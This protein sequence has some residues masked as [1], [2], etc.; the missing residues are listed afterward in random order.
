MLD[1]TEENNRDLYYDVDKCITYCRQIPDTPPS[2]NVDYHMFWRVGKPFGRKQTLPIKSYL[3]TQNRELTRLHVWSNV[4]LTTNEYL[5][6]FLP[7][8]DFHIWDP[9]KEAKGTPI[10]GR[11]EIINA[12]DSLN[13]AG[14]DLFRILCLHKHGG[15]Y[16]DF[17]IVYLRNLGPVLGQEFMYKWSFQEH[18]INGAVMRLWKDSRLG[19]SLLTEIATVPRGGGTAWSTELYQRVRQYNKDWTVFP[20][21]FFNTEWQM[22]SQYRRNHPEFSDYDNDQLTIHIRNPM[23]TSS[24]CNEL[25]DGVFTWHWHNLWDEPICDG[26]KWAVLE[27]KFNAKV[28][29]LYGI[30]CML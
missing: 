22:D 14:G 23:K 16:A 8:I 15:F 21:A 5:R 24:F 27:N 20:C 4:D 12:S 17:D 9:H 30:N 11:R 10:E 28:A 18:M 3:C 19:H 6:P 7:Y 26:S 2:E 1:I 29:E 13:Y 25:Y